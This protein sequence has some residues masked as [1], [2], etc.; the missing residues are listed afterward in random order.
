MEREFLTIDYP[1]HDEQ[2]K[3]LLASLP[4]YFEF[5]FTKISLDPHLVKLML[6]CCIPPSHFI[7]RFVHSAKLC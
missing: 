2:A 6:A 3:M 1:E 4:L 7:E 5:F